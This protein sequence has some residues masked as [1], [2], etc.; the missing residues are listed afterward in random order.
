[1]L[2]GPRERSREAIAEAR[3]SQHKY[4]ETDEDRNGERCRDRATMM[5]LIATA[6][7]E[8]AS[9]DPNERSL[10]VIAFLNSV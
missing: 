5:M 7:A 2:R 9:T 10:G 8:K 1:M 4:R 6:A 3:N